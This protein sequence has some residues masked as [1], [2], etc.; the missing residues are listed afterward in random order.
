MDDGEGVVAVRVS[1]HAGLTQLVRAAAQQNRHV[2]GL[3]L[4]DGPGRWVTSARDTAAVFAGDS[5]AGANPP[6]VLIVDERSPSSGKPATVIQ[7][8]SENS[9]RV[10]R[11]GAFEERFVRQ[12][13]EQTILFVC[14]GNTCR[15]PM[16]EAIAADLLE[17]SGRS[18]AKVISAG[19]GAG[20]GAPPAEEALAALEELGISHRLGGSK[21]LSRRLLAEADRIYVMTRGHLHALRSID[22]GAA[23][24]A[25][26][27]DP[28]GEDVPDP[29]GMSQHVY[30]ETAQHLR[31][32]IERRLRELDA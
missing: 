17:K 16:A 5:E 13:L 2:L 20:S 18:D 15:S 32:L 14:S 21:P 30:T 3:E 19:T 11:P 31:E 4:S 7:I 29:I 28:D 25:E 1:R 6:G 12:Q 22:P 9:V 24:K 23:A 27:L 8:G 26:L 10:V